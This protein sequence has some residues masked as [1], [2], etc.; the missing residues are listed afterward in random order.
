MYTNDT[1]DCL[2]LLEQFITHW[3]VFL[4]PASCYWRKLYL[5]FASASGNHFWATVSF[6]L[7]PSPIISLSRPSSV[8]MENGWRALV[9]LWRVDDTAGTALADK[10]DSVMTAAAGTGLSGRRFSSQERA[11]HVVFVSRLS[12]ASKLKNNEHLKPL[13]QTSRNPL[14]F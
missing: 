4:R 5:R 6:R 12:L 10:T 3:N 7:T 14:F 11:L 2:E 13:K 8:G 9:V 1:S